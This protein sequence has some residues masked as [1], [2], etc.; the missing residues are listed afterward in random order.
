MYITYSLKNKK[1]FKLPFPFTLTQL[2]HYFPLES[3]LHQSSNFPE[4]VATIFDITFFY[5][6]YSKIIGFFA[7][8]D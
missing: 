1:T 2:S 6:Y 4:E 3:F 5:T 7:T 8:E